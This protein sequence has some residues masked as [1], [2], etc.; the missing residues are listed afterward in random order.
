[1]DELDA[2]PAARGR[3]RVAAIGRAVVEIQPPRR[4][5]QA[6]RFEQKVEHRDLALVA[7]HAQRDDVARFVV[8]QRVHAHRDAAAVDGERRAVAD[9]GVPQ[10]AGE[11]GLPAPPLAVGRVP[12]W[13]SARR[14]SSCSAIQPPQRLRR[15]LTGLEPAVALER[16][17]DDV[18]R[19][20]RVLAADLEQQLAL[21][22]GERERIA[23]LARGGAERVE[24]VREVCA[25]PAQQRRQRVGAR[26][27][28]ARRQEPPGRQSAQLR[29]QLA[30]GELGVEHG[31]EQLRA[32]Q[33]DLLGMIF[34][35]EFHPLAVADGLGG[36]QG[37][38]MVGRSSDASMARSRII[39]RKRRR[40]P[41]RPRCPRSGRAP[42]PAA[43]R[44]RPARGRCRALRP[45]ARTTASAR[46]VQRRR[47]GHRSASLAP[48]MRQ[49]LIRARTSGAGASHTAQAVSASAIA[50]SE[51][52]NRAASPGRCT[53]RALLQDVQR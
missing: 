7:K 18:G 53:V 32:E 10:V 23:L 27:V 16:V 46:R 13:P 41:V 39:E 34:R 45:A 26:G 21:R 12:P 30:T 1:M 25:P 42:A 37:R 15:D 38:A 29:Q 22:V 44:G 28:R 8:E 43:R 52:R 9:V 14:G 33:R 50:A 17:E 3:E 49:G 36:D 40:T 35:F 4:A 2:E 5:V 31:A 47:L 24:P 11:R 48:T 20:A 19:H 6:N 51:Y